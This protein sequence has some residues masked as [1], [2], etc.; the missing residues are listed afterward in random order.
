MTQPEAKFKR[1]LTTCFTTVFPRDSWWSYVKPVR[2]GT[3]DLVFSHLTLGTIWLEAKA[4]GKALSGGQEL[5]VASMQGA[6]MKVRV[7][8]A[9]MVGPDGAHRSWRHWSLD[10]DFLQSSRGNRICEAL[11]M[12]TEEFWEALFQ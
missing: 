6:G 1:R 7:I 10:V 2:S 8:D 3:P 11:A 9:H 5:Q 12:T 4:N